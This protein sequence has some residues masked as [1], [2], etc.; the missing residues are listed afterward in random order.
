M[1]NHLP[2][3]HTASHWLQIA[4]LEHQSPSPCVPSPRWLCSAHGL[5]SLLL[6]SGTKWPLSAK[7]CAAPRRWVSDVSLRELPAAGRAAPCCAAHCPARRKWPSLPPWAHG[8]KLITALKWRVLYELG[9]L[10]LFITFFHRNRTFYYFRCRNPR[11][12][13]PFVQQNTVSFFFNKH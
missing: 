9:P 12:W 8:L 3:R 5:P 11:Y 7:R 2:V 6:G 10:L 1:V 4:P 13:F